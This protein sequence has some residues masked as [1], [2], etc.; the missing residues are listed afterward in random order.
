MCIEY[1]VLPFVRRFGL[2]RI[3]FLTEIVCKRPMCTVNA[4]LSTV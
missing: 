3:E 4:L 1:L 2:D